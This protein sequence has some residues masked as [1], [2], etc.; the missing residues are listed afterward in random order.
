MKVGTRLR[1]LRKERK[2]TQEAVEQGC[3]PR[4]AKG[5]L[6]KYEAGLQNPNAETVTRIAAFFAIAP[7]EIDPTV[8]D[9]PERTVER[10]FDDYPSIAEAVPVIRGAGYP[11]WVI[12][13]VRNHRRKGVDDPG[14]AYFVALAKEVYAEGQR[15]LRERSELDELDVRPDVSD[16]ALD[17]EVKK[18]PRAKSKDLEGGR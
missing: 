18:K 4:L 13:S 16:A 7:T 3:V 10:A 2:L 15:A 11:D 14:R 1:Q 9:E 12:E 8:S 17:A 6:S 5:L